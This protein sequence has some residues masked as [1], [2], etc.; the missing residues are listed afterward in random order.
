V[1]LGSIIVVAKVIVKDI[2]TRDTTIEDIIVKDIIV[3]DIM[4]EDTIVEDI[5]VEDI[6]VEDIIVKDI[7]KDIVVT[8][9]EA[10]LLE[11]WTV[12]M[13]M[14]F[15]PSKDMGSN[16]TT[17]LKASF[18]IVEALIVAVVMMVRMN[19]VAFKLLITITVAVIVG[20]IMG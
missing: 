3:K 7:I 16:R 10:D 8:N 17:E 11:D 5:I 9:F 1:L 19:D 14:D 12:M 20:Q 6:I 13:E 2:T 4:V 18:I 15:R